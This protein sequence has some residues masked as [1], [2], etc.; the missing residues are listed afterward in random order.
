MA[1]RK[2]ANLE[3]EAKAQEADVESEE[4]DDLEI[5]ALR[6]AIHN[7][8]FHLL[9]YGDLGDVEKRLLSF[10]GH[11]LTWSPGPADEV[12]F[13]RRF[14]P[15]DIDASVEETSAA[16][17]SLYE[18]GLLERVMHEEPHSDA[19]CVRLVCEP[20]NDRKH[21]T[22]YEPVEFGGPGTRLGGEPT[23]G[24]MVSVTLEGVDERKQRQWG[25]LDEATLETIAR[26]VGDSIGQ[27]RIHVERVEFSNDENTQ[28]TVQYRHRISEIGERTLEMQVLAVVRHHVDLVLSNRTWEL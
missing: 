16:Y 9:L 18:R 2:N 23:T 5:L 7:R 22:P 15:S 21:P 13:S 8:I 3:L 6:E 11:R 19:V 24:Q 4:L 25:L 26:H 12:T 1:G 10:L 17:R 14:L 27:D 28:I 20:F